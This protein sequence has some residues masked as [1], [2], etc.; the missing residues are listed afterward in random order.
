DPGDRNGRRESRSGDEKCGWVSPARHDSAPPEVGGPDDRPADDEMSKTCAAAN[1]G[2][3]RAEPASFAGIDARSIAPGAGGVI[4][5]GRGPRLPGD[6]A[7]LVTI[8]RR[9][10][11]GLLE[12][13][14]RS[15]GA[16][17]PSRQGNASGA[18]VSFLNPTPPRRQVRRLP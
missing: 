5:A 17:A 14:E 11:S 15:R 7:A 4:P 1:R 10:L 16:G 18:R 6:I 3:H 9:L 12:P 8:A 13:T 2:R